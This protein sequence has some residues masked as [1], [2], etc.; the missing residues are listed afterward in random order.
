MYIDIFPGVILLDN[1][2]RLCCV[3]VF[4]L[5]AYLVFNLLFRMKKYFLKS[6]FRSVSLA[7]LL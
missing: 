2:A 5:T 3:I 4:Y 7:V 1:T 6:A